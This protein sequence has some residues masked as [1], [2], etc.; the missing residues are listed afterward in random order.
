MGR[1]AGDVAETV[2]DSSLA[3]KVLNWI[4]TRSL[5]DMCQDSLSWQTKN[6]EGY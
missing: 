4:P 5:K 1:R 2:A 3:K 6:P